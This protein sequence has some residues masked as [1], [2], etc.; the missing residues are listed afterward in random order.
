MEKV[1]YAVR[2]YTECLS[3]VYNYA[4]NYISAY[5]IFSNWAF[6]RKGQ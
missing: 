4:Y 6:V 3:S 5:P 2:C 1:I